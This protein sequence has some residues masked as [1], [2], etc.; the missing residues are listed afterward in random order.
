MATKKQLD[1]DAVVAVKTIDD[2][3]EFLSVLHLTGSISGDLNRMMENLKHV[4][5]FIQM[6]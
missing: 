4:K 3:L 2:V 1:L 5:Q 6:S